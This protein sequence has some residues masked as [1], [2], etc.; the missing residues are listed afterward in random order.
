MRIP[1][2]V[3]DA[4]IAAGMTPQQFCDDISASFRAVFDAFDISYTDYIRTTEERHKR[5]GA[6]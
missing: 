5:V 6:L 3:Q 4:A 2:Q 1:A